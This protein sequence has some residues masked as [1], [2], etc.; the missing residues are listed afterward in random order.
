MKIFKTKVNVK[1]NEKHTFSKLPPTPFF[2]K[3]NQ[4]CDQTVYMMF[5]NY[6]GEYGCIKMD[7][8]E[9]A[10]YCE[11]ASYLLERL[12]KGQDTLLQSEINLKE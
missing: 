11:D 1:K 8:G 6:K 3:D 2:I 10:N 12:N 9:S 4:D 5:K 7:T